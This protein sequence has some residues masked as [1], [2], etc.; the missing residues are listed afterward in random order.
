MCKVEHSTDKG[1]CEVPSL[2]EFSSVNDGRLG[3]F[4]DQNSHNLNPCSFEEFDR[5]H[6]FYEKFMNAVKEFFL[7]SERH[8]FGLV[9]DRAM[10][11]SLGVADSGSWFAVRYLAGCSSCS[12]ILKEEDDLNYVLQRNNYFVKEV[13]KT[14]L[15]IL[16]YFVVY[17][18]MSYFIAPL[19][20]LQAQL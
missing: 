18:K 11:S 10:L 20:H 7:P 1:F 19:S 12:H 6:S 16:L 14:F 4:T 8:R 5:F 3:G 9:S 13:N 15:T 17:A 2:W